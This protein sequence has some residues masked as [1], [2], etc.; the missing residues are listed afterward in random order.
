MAGE[1]SDIEAKQ[2]FATAAEAWRAGRVDLAEQGFARAARLQPDW[3]TAHANLGAVLRRQGKPE[4]A[5]ASYR[6]SLALETDQAATLSNLG[7][8]LR[9]LGRLE[10]AEAALRRSVALE[11]DTI[12]Y[13][14]NLALLLRDRRCHAETAALLERVAAS[15]P[16]NAEYCWDLAL[17]RLYMGDYRRGFEG[18]EARLGL[19][20]NPRRDIAGPRWTGD[21]VTGKR[22]LLTSEQGFGDALQFVRYVPLLAER[23]AAIVLECLPELA[24]LFAG[25]PGV[26]GLVAKG[27]P[28]PPYD[29]WLPM[30]SLPH[31]M[32]TTFDTIPAAS[33]YLVAPPRPNLVIPRPRGTKLSVGLVWAGKTTPR[34]RSWP[35]E[36]LLPLFADPRVTFYS[37]Q[38]GPRT[39]DLARVGAD[40]LLIDAA[41]AL[42]SFADTAA[43][44]ARLDL[45][46]T[47][48]TSIA[49]L[50]GALGR[51]VWVLLRY[52][53]DWRWQDEP[54]DSPWYPTMRLFRQS[55]PFDVKGPV[56]EMAEAL[57]A[58]LD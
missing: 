21:D 31:V 12:S 22:V 52:V 36:E 4:A 43:V 8:A 56:A 1:S 18:Y 39:A 32:G 23:G 27:A 26:V 17:S 5:V 41:P 29:V 9:D 42:T 49:H 11:P 38:M 48:D 34:D 28:L 20:R 16:A 10:E 7:N 15:D 44:M 55:D 35:L 53:S 13:V 50:A 51:P 14:Y 57:N 54:L 19:A 6:R 45:I 25:L 58:L 37:L 24:E 30:A 2:A 46:I 40:R 33:P 3:A 47:I